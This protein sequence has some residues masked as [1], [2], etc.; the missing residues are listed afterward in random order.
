MRCGTLPDV[1]YESPR[2]LDN[3][4]A[5]DTLAAHVA[6]LATPGDAILLDG[7]L[8]IGK[9]AFARAFL[10]AASADPTL[11]VPS[12]TYTIVQSY[13]TRRGPVHHF[14]LWRTGAP[15]DLLELGWDDARRD[16]VLVEWPDRLGTLRPAAALSITFAFGAGPDTRLAHLAGWTDRAL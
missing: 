5:T 3:P 16:I 8:G 12:P 14:D 11:D 7:P 2:L 10:R 4:A 6:A 9:T 1:P 13:E 15:S